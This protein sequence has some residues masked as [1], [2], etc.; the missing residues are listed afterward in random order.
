[1]GASKEGNL[2]VDETITNDIPQISIE[3]NNIITA[4]RRESNTD[5]PNRTKQSTTSEW[6]PN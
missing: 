6:L 3:E 5:N 1:L 2:S 4:L